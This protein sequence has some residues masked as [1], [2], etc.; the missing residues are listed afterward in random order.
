MKYE[1]NPSVIIIDR[2]LF[3][4]DSV[5]FTFEDDYFTYRSLPVYL[6]CHKDIIMLICVIFFRWSVHEKFQPE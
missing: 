5:F 1:V 2:T 3:M 4:F 6:F